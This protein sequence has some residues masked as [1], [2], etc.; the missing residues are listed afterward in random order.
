MTENEGY[1]DALQI[2]HDDLA[3]RLGEVEGEHYEMLSQKKQDADTIDGMRVE[4]Q[5]LQYR[6][7]KQDE[8][9]AE[10]A[11]AFAE[12]QR[13]VLNAETQLVAVDQEHVI[14][15][16]SY[17]DQIAKIQRE[18]RKKTDRVAEVED[19]LKVGLERE[20][21]LARANDQLKAKDERIVEL[22]RRQTTGQREIEPLEDKLADKDS[23]LADIRNRLDET[24]ANQADLKAALRQL[25]AKDSIISVLRDKLRTSSYAVD[26]VIAK[27]K[28]ATREA[29]DRVQE[30]EV[31]KYNWEDEK[32]KLEKEVIAA[33]VD[34]N[35]VTQASEESTKRVEESMDALQ[36][37]QK[38]LQY[39]VDER[40]WWEEER[41]EVCVR[42]VVAGS[43]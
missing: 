35:T 29:L 33:L 36:G 10:A 5:A 19:L 41:L 31:E 8:E 40:Q 15:L 7:T 14:V 27:E 2:A 18:L 9:P 13:R 17:N 28:M 26:E 39:F 16:Q 11:H 21:D 32:Q 22:Q 24:R 6:I 34:V 20:S 1:F 3:Q 30:L 37:A 12:L 23:T 38:E 43:S 42:I 4:C 25:T